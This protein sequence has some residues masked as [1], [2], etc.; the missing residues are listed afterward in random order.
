[1]YFFVAHFEAVNRGGELKI[2][3]ILFLTLPFVGLAHWPRVNLEWLLKMTTP[4]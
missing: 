1:M 2:Q 4:T 3:H